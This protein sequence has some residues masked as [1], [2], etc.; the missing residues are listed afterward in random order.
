MLR[1]AC[2]NNVVMEDVSEIISAIQGD[3]L[4]QMDALILLWMYSRACEIYLRVLF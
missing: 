4:V 1:M 2:V 3:V